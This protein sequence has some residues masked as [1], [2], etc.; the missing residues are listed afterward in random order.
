[1]ITGQTSENILTYMECKSFKSFFL[2]ST[3]KNEILSIAF[4]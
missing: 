4:V 2:Y 3:N 1:M